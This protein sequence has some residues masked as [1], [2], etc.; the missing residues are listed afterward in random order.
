METLRRVTTAVAIGALA[1]HSFAD[2]VHA[3]TSISIPRGGEAT[4]PANCV[5]PSD[6]IVE[7]VP[8]QNHDALRGNIVV[9]ERAAAVK[10]PW[11]ASGI[12]GDESEVPGIIQRLHQR[13]LERGCTNNAGC[14]GVDIQTI[15]R[16][17]PVTM[18]EATGTCTDDIQMI[19]GDRMRISSG[20]VGKGDVRV[21]GVPIHDNLEGTGLVFVL[22][23]DAEVEA[24]WGANVQIIKDCFEGAEAKR[25]E[26]VKRFQRELY[27]TGCTYD[28]TGRGCARVD[29]VYAPGGR[30]ARVN[31]DQFAQR[32]WSEKVGS[33]FNGQQKLGLGINRPQ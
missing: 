3:E 18:V 11:G 6:I 13:Q 2:R 22:N 25:G 31:L 4:V 16:S 29:V 20:A 32:S 33:Y 21:N 9:F 1:A 23:Q 15:R 12:C 28:R 24:P 10:A 27:E 19:P 17:G 30:Q 8:M 26:V 7:G 14:V 5:V